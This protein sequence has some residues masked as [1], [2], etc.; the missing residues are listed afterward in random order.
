[1][2]VDGPVVR[3]SVE[4]LEETGH[5]ATI[6]HTGCRMAIRNF[7]LGRIALVYGLSFAATFGTPYIQNT[8]RISS[9]EAMR[10]YGDSGTVTL[11]D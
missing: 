2:K 11:R 8:L 10:S 6:G 9:A 7:K 5:P 3:S 4:L 1:M